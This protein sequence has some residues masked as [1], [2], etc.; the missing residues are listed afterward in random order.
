MDEKATGGRLR[1]EAEPKA[2]KQLVPE[3]RRALRKLASLLQEAVDDA[4]SLPTIVAHVNSAS[5]RSFAPRFGARSRL[6]LLSAGRGG[7]KTTV[8]VTLA[9]YL[10]LEPRL[11]PIDDAEARTQLEKLRG[12]VTCLPPLDL[13]ATRPSTNLPASILARLETMFAPV[14]PSAASRSA[15]PRPPSFL[16]R[17]AQADVALVWEGHAA[18]RAAALDPQQYAMEV[19]ESEAA[20]L[21]MEESLETVFAELSQG[22]APSRLFLLPVD[23]VDL[24]PTKTAELL[25]LARM[26]S[27]VKGLFFLLLGELRTTEQIFEASVAG[28]VLDLTRGRPESLGLQHGLTALVGKVGAAGIRKLLPPA[29]RVE[30]GGF[31]VDDALEYDGQ[32]MGVALRTL[33][34]EFHVDVAFVASRASP[35]SSKTIPILGGAKLLTAF[36]FLK[37]DNALFPGDERSGN[38][39]LGAAMLASSPRRIADLWMLLREGRPEG[40][41]DDDRI[42]HQRAKAFIEIVARQTKAYLS[43]EDLSASDRA[44]ALGAIENDPVTGWLIRPSVFQV[45]SAPIAQ[46]VVQPLPGENADLNALVNEH[47]GRVML[48]VAQD[49]DWR[50]SVRGPQGE[51]NQTLL[52][53]HH[54]VAGAVFLLHDLLA[55]RTLRGVMGP[56]IL[57]TFD[58]L[59]WAVTDWAPGGGG[60]A[61]TLQWPLAEWGSFFELHNFGRSWTATINQVA[62]RDPDPNHRAEF[63]AFCWISANLLLTGGTDMSTEAEFNRNPSLPPTEADWHRLGKT[64]NDV[65]ARAVGP[66]ARQR[67][68]RLR[69]AVRAA[70]LLLCPEFGLPWRIAGFLLNHD[71]A[72]IASFLRADQA[73]FRRER[74]YRFRILRAPAIA[75]SLL[76]FR[77]ASTGN[78]N[79]PQ[80]GPSSEMDKFA[81]LHAINSFDDGILCPTPD[82]LLRPPWVPAGEPESDDDN[83]FGNDGRGGA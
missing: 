31:T 50:L 23:D 82:D 53:L 16:L 7:G 26:L 20:R 61:E 77:L 13:E 67:I 56:S 59:D 19:I 69:S 8:F 24:N 29:Q 43:E 79:D 51:E 11:P 2:W 38:M 64:L 75:Q 73:R 18:Q 33:L 45:S 27:R 44:A 12:R 49:R 39:Y 41:N 3:Q 58:Q 32:G 63:F 14:E 36:E 34:G 4:S 80:R 1:I 55:L 68:F 10:R 52:T 78:P 37:F 5:D 9:E 15:A 35:P 57:P 65:A 83:L 74:G 48:A 6:A 60:N 22:Q 47:L 62:G 71:F 54:D 46:L 66:L 40:L 76:G 21:R 70:L 42:D 72:G 81:R 25:R 17:R 28:E 30:M